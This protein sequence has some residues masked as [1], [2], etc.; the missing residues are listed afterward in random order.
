MFI[1]WAVCKKKKKEKKQHPMRSYSKTFI[2]ISENCLYKKTETK[3]NVLIILIV[4]SKI[5]G[6][7]IQELNKFIFGIKE[8]ILLPVEIV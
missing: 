4:I 5:S 1:R 2:F 8:I 3:R 7:C 6:M